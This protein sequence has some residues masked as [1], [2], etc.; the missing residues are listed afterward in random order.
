MREAETP[1]RRSWPNDYGNADLRSTQ[2][3]LAPP[4]RLPRRATLH[5]ALTHSTRAG[6]YGGRKIDSAR[7]DQNTIPEAD[8]KARTQ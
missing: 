5:I 2:T 7:T 1:K 8:R 6:P 4:R 3:R